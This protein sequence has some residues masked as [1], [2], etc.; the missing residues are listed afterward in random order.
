MSYSF[1]GRR[2][3]CSRRTD[4]SIHSRQFFSK[5]DDDILLK[6]I[7]AP[8]VRYGGNSVYKALAEK[9]RILL[10]PCLALDLALLI[11]AC[12]WVLVIVSP[13]HDAQ[14]ARPMGG[15]L[16]KNYAQRP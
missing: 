7:S 11:A 16:F 13:S 12:S 1:L 9:V 3:V 4:N 2:P 5:A 15:P 10:K 8:G 14:L 6:A